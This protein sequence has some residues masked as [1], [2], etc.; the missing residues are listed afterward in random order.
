MKAADFDYERPR[1]LAHALSALAEPD[2][3]SRP[4]AGG[5]SLVPLMA[6]RLS[7]PGLLV[8]LNR[9]PGLDGIRVDGTTLHI[10]AMTRQR[11]VELSPV[12]QAHAPLLSRAAAHIGHVTIRNRGTIGGSLAHADSAAEIP[13]AAVALGAEVV[14]TSERGERVLPVTEFLVGHYTTAIEPG[15]LLTE[16]RI[17]VGNPD[18][19]W[20]F[21]EFTQRS[22]D[23]ALAGAAVRLILDGNRVT[24]AV[25][26]PL[27]A[28]GVPARVLAAEQLLEGE[29]LTP[30]RIEQAAAAMDHRELTAVM[31]RRALLEAG[32]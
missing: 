26:V 20:A 13:A 30:Q 3:E 19:H 29:I 9:I 28:G 25:I 2:V 15:E 14:L 5:Q 8:D 31:T 11:D 23:F 12:V 17:D 24:Q 7:R 10:G 4:L 27:A 1:S 21:V 22:G 18:Q 16:V 32:R 6:L